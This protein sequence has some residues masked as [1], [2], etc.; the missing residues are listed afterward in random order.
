MSPITELI[1]GAK[2]YG[3]GSFAAVGDFESIATVTVNGTSQNSITFSS[4]PATYAHLQIRASA[5]DNQSA[6][7]DDG[8]YMYLNGD[9]AAN[10]TRHS[11][12]GDGA[13]VMAYGTGGT[14]IAAVGQSATSHASQS[15]VFAPN[16]I[17]ILDYANTNK[18]KTIRALT[19]M[20]TNSSIGLI[21]P[22][23]CLWMSTSA[24]T[25]IELKSVGG[26][27]NFVEYSHFALYG[28]KEA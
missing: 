1:G 6:H 19:G 20:D 27:Y 22:R 23:S 17:D 5:K 11:I 8:I 14:S 3:W 18:Y 2:A 10:Y 28:I 7:T 4:I 15:D 26:A 12:V 16:V 24:I 21:I 25:S 13:T 9:T